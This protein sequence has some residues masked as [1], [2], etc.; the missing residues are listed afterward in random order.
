MSSF[1][2]PG[3]PMKLESAINTDLLPDEENITK[4]PSKTR[5]LVE[6]LLE[7]PAP[8]PYKK[9]FE[10]SMVRPEE[11]ANIPLCVTNAF[12]HILSQFCII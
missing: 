5:N 7:A 12:K 3:I 8:L 6:F 1:R 10:L 11:W 2:K 9:H 4:S